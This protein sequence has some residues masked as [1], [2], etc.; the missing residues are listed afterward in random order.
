MLDGRG[1]G[2]DVVELVVDAPLLKDPVGLY[3]PL[4]VYME[5]LLY[6]LLPYIPP[7]ICSEYA[8]GLAPKYWVDAV[9]GGY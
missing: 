7:Y 8:P 6:M 2:L 4:L 3:I 1:G 9:V 5:L